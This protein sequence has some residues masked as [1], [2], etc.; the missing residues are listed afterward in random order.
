MEKVQWILPHAVEFIL[1]SQKKT[2]QQD[3]FQS[4]FS[5][6]QTEDS[7]FWNLQ[8]TI[9]GISDP[10]QEGCIYLLIF[11]SIKECM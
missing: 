10:D 9:N 7:I 2:F 5:W 11:T 1:S 4:S 6:H 8:Q 3:H